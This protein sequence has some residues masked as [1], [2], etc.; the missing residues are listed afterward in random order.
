MPDSTKRLV[1]VGFVVVAV[2]LGYQIGTGGFALVGAAIGGIAALGALLAPQLAVTVAMLAALTLDYVIYVVPGVPGEVAWIQDLL[3]AMV[4]FAIIVHLARH[5]T[6][7]GT[8]MLVPLIVLV[9]LGLFSGFINDS[10]LLISVV[11]MRNY[12]KYPVYFFALTQ[13][14]W[15]TVQRERVARILVTMMFI[16]VPVA[17]VQRITNSIA[18]GDVIVGT[19][20]GQ[21]SGT[22]T[23]ALLITVAIVTGWYLTGRLK[24]SVF[25]LTAAALCI[26]VAIN[27]TK[28]FF[29]VGPL[30]FLVL[31]RHRVGSGVSRRMVAVL[32]AVV[33][34]GVVYFGYLSLYTSQSTTLR[35][36]TALQQY[37]FAEQT[38][39]GRVNRLASVTMANRILNDSGVTAQ[40]VGLGP[41]SASESSISGATGKLYS[42]YDYLAIDITFAARFSLEYGWLGIVF[43]GWLCVNLW[44]LAQ[45]GIE[46]ITDRY[47]L[48]FAFGLEAAVFLAVVLSVYTGTFT[49]DV[50]ATYLWVV[51]GLVQVAV[52]EA[53]DAAVGAVPEVL[54]D[55]S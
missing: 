16:Q 42:Q 14:P 10:P 5:R 27:E 4:L 26:P 36:T 17:I 12:W 20:G 11:G 39:L 28:V 51:A 37:L 22:L 1:S 54:A 19:L 46:T 33:L 38:E 49:N 2:L 53:E 8:G 47:W 40:M 35:S 7:R 34:V 52:W 44:R 41:G 25:V 55:G 31:F 15:T 29:F 30:L 24:T 45:R 43:L 50:L 18:S 23:I 6:Y 9:G 3:L 48:G 32:L 13:L 21:A